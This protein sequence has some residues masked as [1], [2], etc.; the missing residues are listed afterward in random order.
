MANWSFVAGNP[1]VNRYVKSLYEV[2]YAAGIGKVVSDQIKAVKDFVLALEDYEKLLKRTCVMKEIG[3]NFISRLNRELNPPKEVGNFIAL[4]LKNKR[5]PL[6]VEICDAYARL[7]DKIEGKKIFRVTGAEALSKSE[8]KRLKVS[9]RGVFGGEIE[10]ITDVDPSLI[11]GMKIQFHS[12]I[13]DYSVKSRL[14][15]LRR[16]VRGESHEN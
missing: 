10:C 6:I 5:L 2:S 13:L 4:L 9:L 1:I 11:G 3:E 15:R 16:A 8:E 12:K 14:A 7:V